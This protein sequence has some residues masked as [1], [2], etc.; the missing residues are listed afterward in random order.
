LN[1]SLLVLGWF[2]SH[3]VS[4]LKTLEWKCAVAE[5]HGGWWRV[6]DVADGKDEDPQSAPIEDTFA[7][8]AEK[9]RR[10]S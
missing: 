6:T 2:L 7:T 10:I 9:T 3:C 8:P 4:T 5:S 1:S